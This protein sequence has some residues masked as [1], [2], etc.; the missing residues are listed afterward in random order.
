[1]GPGSAPTGGGLGLKLWVVSSAAVVARTSHVPFFPGGDPREQAPHHL[2]EVPREPAAAQEGARTSVPSDCTLS[3][4][5][6]SLLPARGHLPNKGVALRSLSRGLLLGED[7]QERKQRL[8][9][10]AGGSASA[11]E[12]PG[13]GLGGAGWRSVQ[14]GPGHWLSSPPWLIQGLGVPCPCPANPPLGIWFPSS[15]LCLPHTCWVAPSESGRVRDTNTGPGR[16]QVPSRSCLWQA[17]TGR[18]SRRLPLSAQP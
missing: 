10:G 11:P 4:S 7:I 2:S 5:G 3:S 15:R 6:S 18:L 14:A 9:V 1:M 13:R 12:S 16:L 8:R 17:A